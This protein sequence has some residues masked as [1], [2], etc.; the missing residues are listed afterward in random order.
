[1]K[2][3]L[4]VLTGAGISAE[5]GLKTFR[6]SD[7]LWEQYRIEDVATSMAWQ[8]DPELVLG[9]YNQ[10]RKD[11]LKAQPNAAHKALMKLEEY[12][13]VT[14]ITQNIDDLHERAGSKNVIHLHGEILKSRS[15]HNA[16]LLYDCRDEIKMGDL[17][18]QGYQLR[19]H[20]VWFHEAVPMMD[21]AGRETMKAEILVVIG[22]SLQVYPAAGLINYAPYG[23]RKFLV[24]PNI[25]ADLS[26]GNVTL[27]EAKAS[28]GVPL[29]AEKLIKEFA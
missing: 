11:V 27:I 28:E 5:S 15:S 29:L 22:T 23:A 17:C 3:N 1:M 13:N 12:F 6:N 21:V 20:V 4:V 10:R 18:E 19:P 9:F 14:I 24:D 8:R 26:I 16:N 25:P 2:K 7:G